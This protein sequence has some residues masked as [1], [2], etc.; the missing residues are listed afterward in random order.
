MST[1]SSLTFDQAATVAGQGVAGLTQ[2]T[3]ALEVLGW[4]VAMGL[5]AFR[6]P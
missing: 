3:L 6:S 2:R 5:L 4:F 1:C